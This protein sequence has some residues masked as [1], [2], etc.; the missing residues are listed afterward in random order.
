MRLRQSFA[1][2]VGLERVCRIATANADGVPHSVP[3]VHVLR[4]GKVYFASETGSKKV[5]NIRKN[6]NVTVTVD[7]YSE[8]WSNLKGVMIQGTATIIGKSPRFRKLR[9]LLYEK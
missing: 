8:A 9:A 1:K 5:R 2:L 3:V 7:V 6:P 4:D